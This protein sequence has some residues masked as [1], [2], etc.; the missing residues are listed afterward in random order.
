MAKPSYD[1]QR[2]TIPPLVEIQIIINH[3]EIVFY[4]GC[5]T[6][7]TRPVESSEK[8]SSILHLERASHYIAE[9]YRSGIPVINSLRQAFSCPARRQQY[10]SRQFSSTAGHVTSGVFCRLRSIAWLLSQL[11]LRSKSFSSSSNV[12]FIFTSHNYHHA[13]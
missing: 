10:S 9:L 3:E 1:N 2:T 6:K 13:S 5:Y 11:R 4:N 8:E 7:L 12:R